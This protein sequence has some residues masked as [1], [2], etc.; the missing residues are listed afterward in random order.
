MWEEWPDIHEFTYLSW[1]HSGGT[2]EQERQRYVDEF[3]QRNDPL[4]SDGEG[5]TFIQFMSRVTGALERLRYGEKDFV[6]VF[7]HGY[8]MRA[9]WW[10]LQ[11]RPT[12]IE[13]KSM[14]DFYRLRST[15]D[16]PNGAI[17]PIELRG[18]EDFSIGELLVPPLPRREKSPRAAIPIDELRLL[19]AAISV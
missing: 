5:E 10:Y 7:T 2:T 17:L 15:L 6:A 9:V 4:Y 16:I 12:R 1:S 8:F 13:G 3:W 11:N 18:R 14:E 19:A